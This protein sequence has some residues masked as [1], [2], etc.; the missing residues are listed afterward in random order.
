MI[1]SICLSILI[2]TETNI[3]LNKCLRN[4][5]RASHDSG[6][7][8]T[9]FL[10]HE[11]YNSVGETFV[12]TNEIK[13]G[14]KSVVN[15]EEGPISWNILQQRICVNGMMQSFKNISERLPIC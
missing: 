14:D 4:L 6:L 10:F 5:V 12:M 15:H 1:F 9:I 2:H 3:V 11:W 13:L 8:G 7:F